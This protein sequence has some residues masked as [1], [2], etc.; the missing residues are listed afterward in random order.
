V[1]LPVVALVALLV[2]L[3]LSSVVHGS[4]GLPLPAPRFISHNIDD[5]LTLPGDQVVT[6]PDGTYTAGSV[7]APHGATRGPYGG[8][9]ILVAQHQ[10]QVVIDPGFGD[11]LWLQGGPDGVGTSRVV[12]VGFSFRSEVVND[13]FNVIFWYCDHQ[14]PDYGYL[15][16]PGNHVPTMFTAGRGGASGLQVYG[17]DFHSAVATPMV[18]GAVT[19]VTLQ[20]VRVYGLDGRFDGFAGA[21]GTD[22]RNTIETLNGLHGPVS[23]VSVL[24]TYL[25]G[26]FSLWN[27]NSGTDTNLLWQDI[28]YAY[29][30]ATPFQL[31]SGNGNPVLNARR[32]NWQVFGP[33]AG[34]ATDPLVY[35]DGVGSVGPAAFDQQNRVQLSDVNVSYGYPPD[36]SS[37]RDALASGSNPANVWRTAHPYDTWPAFFRWPTPTAAAS[38]PTTG[39]P[40]SYPGGTN[41]APFAM[42]TASSENFSTGQVA[43]KV[44]DGSALG[45]P[46]DYTR[47]W[48]TVGGGVGSWLALSWNAPVALD[49]V[50]LYDRPN[51]N[52]QITAATLT[53]DDGT[54]LAVPSLPNNGFPLSVPFSPRATSRLLLTIAGVSA[55]T[56]NIGLAEIEAWSAPPRAPPPTTSSSSTP[57][58]TTTSTSVPPPAAPPPPPAAPPP[59]PAAPPP[60]S[61]LNSIARIQYAMGGP[62]EGLPHGV[63]SSYSWASTPNVVDPTDASGY[64]ALTGWGLIYADATAAEPAPGTV[65][66]EFK[67]FV[68]YVWSKSQSKWAQVQAV[69]QLTGAHYTEDLVNNASTATDWR[70]EPDGG[71]SSGIVNGYNLHFYPFSRG[72]VDPTDVGGVF[73]SY[74]VRLIG[75]N[76][77]TASYLANAGADW[78]QT[79]SAPFPNNAGVGQGRFM[80]LSPD[81]TAINFYSG[82]GYG[83]AS[84]PPAWTALQLA[85]SNPPLDPMGAP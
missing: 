37:M 13:A 36:V 66:V 48:A 42:V 69:A 33:L 72:S 19:N 54:T 77:A 16:R 59:P 62:H 43:A 71:I 40:A 32:V 24:D 63:P 68:S 35:V 52:D 27:T 20:G 85:T 50:V 65:R 45:Y 78:W 29:G 67:H 3:P 11:Q 6:V 26:A 30:D 31:S 41:I 56:Q 38:T 81:W 58:P 60:Q 4:S 17:D 83:P 57:T 79:T 10:G 47:E 53:F 39:P 12:F 22:P 46:V 7:V 21:P 49:H 73:V 55:T 34:A 84:Y 9:L 70:T 5:Y 61:T 14:D 2:A 15:Q 51:L 75:A 74:Q 28:W 82:G 44:V 23:N 64:A 80:Y 1:A 8:W 18:F 76:A 25:E